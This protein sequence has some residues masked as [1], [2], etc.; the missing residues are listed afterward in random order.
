MQLS[1]KGKYF[2]HFF[3]PFVDLH[4]YL[5]ISKKRWYLQTMYFRSLRLPNMLLDKYL[6]SPVSEHDSTV[7]MLRVYKYLWNLH[8]ITFV[9]NLH[10]FGQNWLWKCLLVI[11]EILGVFVNTLTADDKYNLGN[12]ANLQFPITM[13]LS[14]KLKTFSQFF[15]P[16]LEFTSN[17]KHF[18]QKMI[19]IGNVF[20]Q[21]LT[22]EDLVRPLYKKRCFRTPFDSQHVKGSR[23]SLKSAWEQ[24]YH[25]F[26]S[27][28]E[29]LIWKMSLLVICEM[30]GAI[31]NTQTIDDKYPIQNCEN[32]KLPIQMQLSNKRT[33]L[34]R[35]FPPFLAFT[36]IFKEF[37]RNMIVISKVFPKLPT[38]K[39]LVRPLSKKRCFRT[40]FDSQHVKESQTFVKSAWEHFYHIFSSLW[41]KLIWKMSLLVIYEILGAIVNTVTVDDNYLF[42]NCEELPL[43]IQM[44]L[45]NEKHFSGFL[46]HFWHLHQIIQLLQK[47]WL[48]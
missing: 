40:P 3:V 29:K 8:R 36:S 28:L 19:F 17:F 43:S 25:I 11:C 47:R 39:D 1:G 15:V 16:Y 22:V 13:Q 30:F 32:L 34:S 31:F 45:S 9:L 26:S 35:V 41:G 38:V 46:F 2:T 27:L 42:R 23:T 4:Q 21:L 44:Q 12:C 20:P 6:K 14:K 24:F 37:E 5:N 18:E 7:N 10:H 33:T 48:L